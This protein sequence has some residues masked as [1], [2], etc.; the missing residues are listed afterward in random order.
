MKEI[1]KLKKLI[2]RLQK[3]VKKTREQRFKEIFD[4]YANARPKGI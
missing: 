3:E 4:E 1:I 2:N